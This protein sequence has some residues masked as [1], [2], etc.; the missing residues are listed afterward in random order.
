M[1]PLTRF[2]LL[3]LLP[4]CTLDDLSIPELPPPGQGGQPLPPQVE[5]WQECEG[6]QD[7]SCSPALLGCYMPTSQEVE[8]AGHCTWICE[9][10][11]DCAEL[12]VD[13]LAKPICIPYLEKEV[14]VCALSC[15]GD[16]ECPDGMRCHEVETDPGITASIC[17]WVRIPAILNTWIGH[18]ERRRTGAKRRAAV[19]L[20][21]ALMGGQVW[22]GPPSG[23]RRD[24][25][26]SMSRWQ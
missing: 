15:N 24:G 16:G 3:A 13:Q 6:W 12:W 23:L 2:L 10:D 18:R 17:T 14:G 4:S 5:A 8:L 25:P 1:H 11:D 21:V 9:N 19:A 7:E 26:F 20:E 22:E